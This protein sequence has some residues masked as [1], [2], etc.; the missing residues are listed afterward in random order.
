MILVGIPTGIAQRSRLPKYQVQNGSKNPMPSA[1]S[2]C[3]ESL[4]GL[5]F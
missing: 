2:Y 3:M 5:A 4:T 1:A